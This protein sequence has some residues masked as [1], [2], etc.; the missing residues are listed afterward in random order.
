MNTPNAPIGYEKRQR[1]SYGM[2]FLDDWDVIYCVPIGTEY[3]PHFRHSNKWSNWREEIAAMNGMMWN[4]DWM[5][6]IT[7]SVGDDDDW[8]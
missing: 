6:W 4:D 1:T 8:K 2:G 3:V 5:Q 7:P